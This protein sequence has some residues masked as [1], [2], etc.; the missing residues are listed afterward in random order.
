MPVRTELCA[1]KDALVILDATHTRPPVRPEEAS[2]VMPLQ[3]SLDLDAPRTG[4]NLANTSRAP[5]RKAGVNN[6][7][8]VTDKRRKMSCAGYGTPNAESLQCDSGLEAKEQPAA[9]S[10]ATSVRHI[11]VSPLPSSVTATGSGTVLPCRAPHR[12]DV[13]LA[14]RVALRSRR[15]APCSGFPVILLTTWW[16]VESCRQSGSAAG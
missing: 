5:T 13:P 10:S 4:T 7:P 16:G 15:P 3:Q 9:L 8:R 14:D 11:P 12:A 2:C 1:A 6:A